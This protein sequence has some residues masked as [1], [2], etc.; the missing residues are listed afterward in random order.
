MKWLWWTRLGCKIFGHFPAYASTS[1]P[2]NHCMNCKV[3]MMW[4]PGTEVW[5][6]TQT[7]PAASDKR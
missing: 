1:A 5:D 4:N 6:V 7:E 2:N 3:P